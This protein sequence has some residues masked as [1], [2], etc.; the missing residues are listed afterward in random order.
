M[1]QGCFGCELATPT[2]TMRCSQ[3]LIDCEKHGQVPERAECE[4]SSHQAAMV[5]C[6]V[7]KKE[8]QAE[9]A[10]LMHGR[11]VCDG[12]G[13]AVGRPDILELEPDAYKYLRLTDGRLVVW[14]CGAT[15]PSHATKAKQAGENVL[16]AG[17]FS[18]Q[19]VRWK[20]MTRGSMTLNIPTTAL[21]D[22][23]VLTMLLGVPYGGMQ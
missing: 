17:I 7:C 5:K 11:V 9:E 22:E 13:T 10:F 23:D 18:H 14:K 2:N 8:L 20:M 12:H 15:Q 3:M 21:D 4:D 19:G 1:K 16:S 6:Y